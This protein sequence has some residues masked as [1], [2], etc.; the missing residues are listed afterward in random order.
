LITPRRRDFGG[1]DLVRRFRGKVFSPFHADLIKIPEAVE[2]Q[3]QPQEGLQRDQSSAFK[4][5]LGTP[6][7]TGPVRQ[8]FLAQIQ[9]QT[10]VR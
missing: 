3:R 5:L 1:R 10:A 9:R 8:T 7:H 2:N 4:T 6:T